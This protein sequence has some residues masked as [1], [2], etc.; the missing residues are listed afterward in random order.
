MPI[1]LR[2]PDICP[3][4]KRLLPVAILASSGLFAQDLTGVWQGVVSPP[5]NQAHL[6]TV[7]KVAPAEDGVNKAT[8]YS[9]DQTYLG[10]PETFK[11]QGAVVKLEIPGIGAHYEAKLSKDGDSM[12]GTIKAGVFPTP[13]PWTL[14]RVKPEEAWALREPPKPPA[15]PD[16]SFEVATVIP[17]RRAANVNPM[18]ALRQ[19]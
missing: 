2:K 17:A 11:L 14:K 19:E 7:L 15:N 6:R 3:S 4:L 8:F 16:P 18:V 10:I 13:V 9:I 5:D 12:E 1:C